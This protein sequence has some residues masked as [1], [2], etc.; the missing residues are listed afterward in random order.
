MGCAWPRRSSRPTTS[1]ASKSS[2]ESLQRRRLRRWVSGLGLEQKGKRRFKWIVLH[3]NHWQEYFLNV[4]NFHQMD[5]KPLSNWTGAMACLHNV[6]WPSYISEMQ[7][8]SE[9]FDLWWVCAQDDQLVW[10]TSGMILLWPHTSQATSR[11]VACEMS[12]SATELNFVKN[13]TSF[14]SKEKRTFD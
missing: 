10:R 3:W 2:E 14:A 13:A 6:P 11:T 5:S 12:T 7:P 1:R 9:L 8:L 4:D